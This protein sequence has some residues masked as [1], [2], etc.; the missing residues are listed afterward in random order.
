MRVY[1]ECWMEGMAHTF[2]GYV[3][4]PI[5][6]GVADKAYEQKKTDAAGLVLTPK[7]LAQH[8]G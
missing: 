7:L 5:E 4:T 1:G 3:G 2:W 8:G 6:A